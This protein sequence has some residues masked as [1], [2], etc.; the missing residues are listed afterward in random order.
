MGD[1]T[2][3][4]SVRTGAPW[5]LW[6][7]IIALVAAAGLGGWMYWEGWRV[8]DGDR[9]V[10]PG[11]RP[12]DPGATAVGG[13]DEIRVTE[14]HVRG[15]RGSAGETVEAVRDVTL[16]RDTFAAALGVTE[17]TRPAVTFEV[18]VRAVRR[19]EARDLEVHDDGS[20][21]TVRVDGM[22]LPQDWDEGTT[23]WPQALA[24]AQDRSMPGTGWLRR[25][26]VDGQGIDTQRLL[27]A[28]GQDARRIMGDIDDLRDLAAGDAGCGVAEVIDALGLSRDVV[29]FRAGREVPVVC[30]GVQPPRTVTLEEVDV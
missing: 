5:W 27:I 23:T 2:V 29:V 19:V 17:S 8:D 4:V 24:A 26:A 28:A 6:L 1:S 14:Q 13:L 20:I 3:N 10:L 15:V 25:R 30:G 21:V 11:D 18:R 22:M 7:L 16:H 12:D 9:H